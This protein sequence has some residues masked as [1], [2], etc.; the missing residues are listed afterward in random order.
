[1][2]DLTTTYL[3]LSLR[4][5]VVA[6]AGPLSQSVAGI[7]ALADGGVGAVVM[8][9]L[10][11]EQLRREAE[12]AAALEEMYDNSFPEALS[13]FPTVPASQKDASHAYLKLVE[14]GAKAIDVPL[15]AS[16]NGAS[17]GG[18]TQ[19]A[20]RLADAGASAIELNIYFVPGDITMT[21]AA[22]EERHL[23]I[24]AA[25]KST[26]DVPVAAKISPYFSSVGNMV[27]RLVDAGADGV[28]LF[29]RFLQPDIDVDRVTVESGVSLSSPVEARLPRTWIAVLRGKI[30][31]SLAATTGVDR[32]ED[33]IKYILAGSDVVMTTSS[34]IRRGPAYAEVLVDELA[35]WLEDRDLT[36]HQAR[37]LLSVPKEA[38]A[39]VY[40]RA[41]YVSALEKAKATYGSLR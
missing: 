22:V 12:V 39:D 30:A 4:N 18:W 17:M 6:S 19:Q 16:L 40:E 15:I 5:P 24:V 34:L 31:A 38:P 13:Y 14:Q 8:Y 32:P 7:K 1:M 41:G 25:V 37:G 27:L 20:R 36:L 11:E 28:V 35:A 2:T 21:G 3:G 23:E 33:V 10:F 29:N 26:V 9:S